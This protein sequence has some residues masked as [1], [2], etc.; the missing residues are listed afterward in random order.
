VRRLKYLLISIV[1]LVRLVVGIFVFLSTIKLPWFFKYLGWF[2]FLVEVMLLTLR[3]A[4]DVFGTNFCVL[5]KW[6]GD[7]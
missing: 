7:S 5:F 1:V 2:Q 4:V 3:G 6:L